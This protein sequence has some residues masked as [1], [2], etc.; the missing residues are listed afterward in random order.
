MV[1]VPGV[2]MS[3]G[4][5]VDQMP[6]WAGS[7]GL[8]VTRAS[9][10]MTGGIEPEY[11]AGA[12]VALVVNNGEPVVPLLEGHGI[13]PAKITVGDHFIPLVAE[14]L[15]YPVLVKIHPEHAAVVRVLHADVVIAIFLGQE[16]AEEEITETGRP[17]GINAHGRVLESGYPA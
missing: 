4:L 3:I 11:H 13:V 2:L 10:G 1:Y 14:G 5:A 17:A 12:P 6:D 9:A 16:I 7:E 15:E 8:A